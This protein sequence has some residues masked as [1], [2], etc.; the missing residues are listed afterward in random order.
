MYLRIWTTSSQSYNINFIDNITI[1]PNEAKL[2]RSNE[3][4]TSKRLQH[5]SIYRFID[6]GFLETLLLDQDLP[7]F[8]EIVRFQ[9]SRPRWDVL[10]KFLSLL[11]KDNIHKLNYSFPRLKIIGFN[12]YHFYDE[13][14]ENVLGFTGKLEMK[15]RWINSYLIKSVQSN[16]SQ[17][18]NH[19]SFVIH[20]LNSNEIN[21]YQITFKGDVDFMFQYISFRDDPYWLLATQINNLRINGEVLSIERYYDDNY[22]KL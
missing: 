20:I 11:T 4:F 10:L 5:L 1:G 3:N 17:S 19:N 9:L 7:K 13:F 21:S 14:E 12:L 15:L 8:K 2:L 6:E 22:H 18:E 16:L